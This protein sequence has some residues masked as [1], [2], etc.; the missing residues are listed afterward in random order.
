M[1]YVQRKNKDIFKIER[2][3]KRFVFFE[4]IHLVLT[5]VYIGVIY[6]CM[7][8]ACCFRQRICV[9]Q[10]PLNGVVNET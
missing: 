7:F 4:F 6:M 10:G 8:P 9:A 1:F 5:Y 3:R 2:S